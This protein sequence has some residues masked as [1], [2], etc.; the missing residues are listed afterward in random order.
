[1]SKEYFISS[2][3]YTQEVHADIDKY[4]CRHGKPAASAHF[5]RKQATKVSKSSDHLIKLAYLETVKLK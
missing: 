2:S 5:S 3:R 1:M 4:A